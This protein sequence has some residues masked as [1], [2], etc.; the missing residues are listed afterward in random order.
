VSSILRAYT[1]YVNNLFAIAVLFTLVACSGTPPK[2]KPADLPPDAGLLGV[3]QVWGTKT[4]E[5]S[6]PLSVQVSAQNVAIASAAGSVAVLNASTGA[7]VWRAA[8]GSP[9]AAGV[10]YDGR[11]AAVVT[12][13]N[14]LV[15]LE[16]GRELWRQQLTAQSYTAPLVAGERVFVLA[17]DRSVIA[18][19]GQS[20]RR[21]WSQQ[22]PGEALVLRQSGV[23]LA[24]GDTLVIG[25]SGKLLGM[26]PLNGNVRWEAPIASPRGTN[27]VE[28]LVDLVGPVYRQGNLVCARA[29]QAAVGCVDANRGA[30]LWTKPG[31]GVVGVSGDDRFV[32]GV[33]ADSTLVAWR[34]LD[35]ERA[36][37]AE[38]LR[39]RQL[40]TPVVIGQSVVVGDGNGWLHFLS[41]ENG[42]PLTRV[43]TDGSPIMVAPALVGNTLVVVTRNG[44]IFGFRPE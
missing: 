31:S 37:T 41:R 36:W 24:V 9:L 6:F 7:E 38:Q 4:G 40:S 29:F 17:A 32:F 43:S 15:V 18:Y 16:S 3:K 33:E 44:G 20:G 1:K 10:G 22:R 19:D 25:L 5:V 28:R 8:V 39:Y 2:H 12:R 14:E 30:L 35:G 21:L 11:L 42:A 13:G 23:L 26:N 27:D 34:R